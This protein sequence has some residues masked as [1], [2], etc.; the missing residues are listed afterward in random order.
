MAHLSEEYVVSSPDNVESTESTATDAIGHVRAEG[1][2]TET[3]A[4]TPTDQARA[5]DT[6]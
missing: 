6:E 5:A 4:E 3:S 1:V 2:K